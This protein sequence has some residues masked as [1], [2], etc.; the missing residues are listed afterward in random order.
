MVTPTITP[1]IP[2]TSGRAFLAGMLA[3]ALQVGTGGEATAAYYKARGSK[4]YA[5]AVYGTP[6]GAPSV[7]DRSPA[8]NFAQVRA[9]L[10][11]AVKDLAEMIG[12]SRQAIY[13]W[14]SGAAIARKH[15]GRLAELAKAA[16]LFAVEG[17]TATPQA[18]R[19]PIAAGHSFLDVV[20]GGGSVADA[21]SSLIGILRREAEQRKALEARLANRPQPPLSA[22]DLGIPRLDERG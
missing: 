1:Y 14:Q 19:R 4:G 15:A 8:E 17:L 3:V 11:P 20:R 7:V 18:L 22:D 5:M 16:D 9:V 6:N 12:V 10:K 13:D 21:A 2:I